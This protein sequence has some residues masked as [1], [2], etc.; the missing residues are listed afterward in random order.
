MNFSSK[1]RFLQSLPVALAA[2]L[3]TGVLS[4]TALAWDAVGHQQVADIAW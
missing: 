3:L 2:T 1:K 4:P